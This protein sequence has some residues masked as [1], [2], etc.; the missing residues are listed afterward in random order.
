VVPVDQRDVHRREPGQD[1][2][3]EVAVEEVAAGEA[4]LV[5][6]RIEGG[7]GVDDVE[8]DVGPQL[9]QHLLG[10]L[11]AQGADLDH[12]LRPRGLDHRED[13]VVPELVHG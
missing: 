8:L 10:V 9:F 13:D 3:A 5:F 2:H 11:A 4:G 7:K 12:A 6:G 1:V